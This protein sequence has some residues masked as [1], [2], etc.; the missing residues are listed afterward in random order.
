MTDADHCYRHPDRRAGVTCQRCERVICPDCMRQASVG[1][2]CPECAGAG[3]RQ[4]VVTGAQLRRGIEKPT[5][6]N[7]LIAL[8]LAA[9]LWSVV[10]GA[11]LSGSGIS[12][13]HNDYG[14][15]GLFRA[16]LYFQN[17]PAQPIP[18]LG[19]VAYGEWYRIFT[20]A[21]LHG[22]LLHV[23]MNMYVLY[24][25]GPQM[26]RELGHRDFALVY[27]VA[28]VA[29]SFGALLLD[30]FVPTVGASGAIYGLFGAALVFQR[31][32][33][34]NP[35]ASGIAG[36]LLINLFITFAIPGISIGGHVGG[37][38]GGDLAAIV[39]FEGETR[40]QPMLSVL[41]CA[42]LG[43]GFFLA[44]IWAAEQALATLQPVLDLGPLS[45]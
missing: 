41:G 12:D 2:H 22:G 1:F 11:D 28:L 18:E 34:I 37:L 20:G 21:F 40:R 7:I 32:S 36:L 14:I 42:G 25:L 35:W 4:K 17:A 13:V 26:E 3:S 24:I 43:L 30:P 29:G 15:I 44:A 6:T 31:R 19:G 38:L 10:A 23:G 45:R 27:G 39:V 9:F 16:D 5:V 8:N 33:G